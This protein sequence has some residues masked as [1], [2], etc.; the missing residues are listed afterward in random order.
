MGRVRGPQPGI[1]TARQHDGRVARRGERAVHPP[2][3]RVVAACRMCRAVL[4]VAPA[5][6]QCWRRWG[7]KH[8]HA[9]MRA[10]APSVRGSGFFVVVCVLLVVAQQAR[11]KSDRSQHCGKGMWRCA[12]GVVWCPLA[13]T[14]AALGSCRTWCLL[15]LL[16]PTS[17]NERCTCIR[18]TGRWPCTTGN[19][20]VNKQNG[21]HV[22]TEKRDKRRL[23]E[24]RMH[25][26]RR[27]AN[28]T[29][30]KQKRKNRKHEQE[31]NKREATVVLLK[32]SG[33]EA[34]DA[35]RSAVD[36]TRRHTLIAEDTA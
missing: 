17:Q 24:S 25:M 16:L 10:S 1:K 3:T 7:H 33:G 31:N 18:S 23:M 2:R 32:S 9:C 26:W 6:Q 4:A 19:K 27:E 15:P 13:A 35:W 28:K 30:R 14:T 36:R 20:Q 5:R 29:Q 11:K 21:P 8:M 22:C 34:T 12:G